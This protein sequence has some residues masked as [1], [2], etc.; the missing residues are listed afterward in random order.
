MTDENDCPRI[1]GARTYNTGW[2]FVTFYAI[3]RTYGFERQ[4]PGVCLLR[5]P[6]V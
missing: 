2:A 3:A 6:T 1:V 4:I 5:A